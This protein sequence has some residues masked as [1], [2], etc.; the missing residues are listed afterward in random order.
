MNTLKLSQSTP[1][2]HKQTSSTRLT[3]KENN[4]NHSH[5]EKMIEGWEEEYHHMDHPIK[6][7]FLKHIFP[8][9]PSFP[10]SIPKM[11]CFPIIRTYRNR[12]TPRTLSTP[13]ILTQH[14]I[15]YF[16]EGDLFIV[17]QQT[18]FRIH[19]YFLVRESI[20][21]R[22]LLNPFLHHS[23]TAPGISASHPL[24]LTDVTS[25]NFAIFLWVFYT[26]Y[27]GY[28]QHSIHNWLIIHTYAVQWGIPTVQQLAI[29][30][31]FKP[32]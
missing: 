24:I 8:N 15:Y 27:F 17:T 2:L 3:M 6:T 13:R 9:R 19:S 26:P 30:H 10:V 29:S 4:R 5:L 32:R 25:T 14:P 1:N 18:Q 16:A 12:P 28:Y 20:H 22:Q 31:I 11:P 7:T 21:F 23:S